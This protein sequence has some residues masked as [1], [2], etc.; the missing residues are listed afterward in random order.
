VYS[1][2]VFEKPE[3]PETLTQ[4]PCAITYTLGVKSDYS[5]GG[6]CVDH[7][8]GV[9]EFHL[10]P[11]VVK[12]H[13]PYIMLF[14]RRIR[15]AAAGSLTLGGRVAHFLLDP[16]RQPNI[17]GPVALVYGSEDPHHALVVYWVVKESVSGDFVVS[18]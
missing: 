18:A 17:Q 14:F 4:Y 1:Y 8:E 12:S 9:T 6:P 11:N 3:F 5:V 15:D 2:R 16:D 10:T 13:F 7:W